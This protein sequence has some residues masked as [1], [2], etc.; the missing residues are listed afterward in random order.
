MKKQ[1]ISEE[2]KRMQKLAG[3]I[4]EASTFTSKVDWYYVN[5][6]SDYPGP[7]GRVVPDTEGYYS[8]ENYE[9]TELYMPKGTKG[10]VEGDNFINDEGSNV[11]FEPEYFEEYSEDQ[12]SENE[13]SRNIENLVFEKGW[14]SWDDVENE[15]EK[16]RE[17]FDLLDSTSRYDEAYDK[18]EQIYQVNPLVIKKYFKEFQDTQINEELKRM[19]KLAGIIIE[20]Q[21]TEYTVDDF[22]LQNDGKDFFQSFF[23]AIYKDKTQLDPDKKEDWAEII[24]MD[25]EQLEN[26]YGLTPNVAAKVKNIFTDKLKTVK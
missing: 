10:Y 5:D 6:N 13:I 23:D 7:K 12:I 3:I 4:N 20:S 24:K 2:F 8:P 9:G 26:N 21:L 17:K 11:P 15:I 14:E 18:F 22:I 19:Q 25:A 16:I 1:I